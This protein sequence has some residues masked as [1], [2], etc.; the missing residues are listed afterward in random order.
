MVGFMGKHAI[1]KGKAQSLQKDRLNCALF[2]LLGES[3]RYHSSVMVCSDPHIPEL[4]KTS[5]KHKARARL[6]WI[7]LFAA[8]TRLSTRNTLQLFPASTTAWLI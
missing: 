8:S 4:P 6:L 1:W 5:R 2:Y 3:L 7:G